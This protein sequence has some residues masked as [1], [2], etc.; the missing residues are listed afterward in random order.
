MQARKIIIEDQ[1]NKFNT[2]LQG[3]QRKIEH[4]EKQKD[5]ENLDG[6]IVD[7]NVQT[8]S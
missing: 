5:K 2:R 4:K 8:N 1:S 3:M 7:N 6:I